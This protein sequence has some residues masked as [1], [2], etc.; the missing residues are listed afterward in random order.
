L[1]VELL[2]RIVWPGGKAGVRNIQAGS[3][4]SSSASDALEF[5]ANGPWK[6]LG[7]QITTLAYT[8]SLF[9]TKLF[10][11]MPWTLI[12]EGTKKVTF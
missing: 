4:D 2:E 3:L 5:A 10:A 6:S 1:L 8:I 12:F 11:E 9:Q 7:A